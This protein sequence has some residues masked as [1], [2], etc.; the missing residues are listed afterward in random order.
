MS[1]SKVQ[2]QAEKPENTMEIV[3]NGD[4]APADIEDMD[5]HTIVHNWMPTVVSF[6]D[7]HGN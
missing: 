6:V 4:L 3:K 7:F 1:Q 2:E 5:F